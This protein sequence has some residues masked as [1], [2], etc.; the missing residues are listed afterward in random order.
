MRQSLIV[1]INIL[2]K[3]ES[4]YSWNHILFQAFFTSYKVN[5]TFVIA[6]KL[7]GFFMFHGSPNW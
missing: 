2:S 3:S 4:V 1:L 7:M 5:Q 6:V